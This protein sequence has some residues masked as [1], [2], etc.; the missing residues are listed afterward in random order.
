MCEVYIFDKQSSMWLEN[1]ILRRKTAELCCSVTQSCLTLFNL[2]HYSRLV[3]SILH[4]LPVFAQIFVHWAS[5]PILT[6]SCSASFFC[7]CLHSFPGSSFFQMNW[8]FTSGKQ[9]IGTLASAS[10]LLMNIQSWFPLVL[11]GLISLLS[12]GLSRVFSS[13]TVWKHQFFSVQPS[14]GSNS[15]VCTWLLEKP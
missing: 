11:T 15:H 4:H 13:T 7:F 9:N 5:D 6:I 1:E 8:L 12:K 14:L 2:M 3:C 10:V